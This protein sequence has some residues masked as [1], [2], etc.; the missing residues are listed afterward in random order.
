MKK[1]EMDS[2]PILIHYYHYFLNEELVLKLSKIFLRIA[3]IW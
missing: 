1:E 3:G 2:A